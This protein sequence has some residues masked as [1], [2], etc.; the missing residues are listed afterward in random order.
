MNLATTSFIRAAI[1][2]LLV[3][4]TYAADPV[5]LPVTERYESL[6][7]EAAT[8]WTDNLWGQ[9]K[10]RL[11]IE[12]ASSLALAIDVEGEMA[13]RRRLT[14]QAGK[15]YD[16]RV[17]VSVRGQVEEAHLFLRD[18]NRP[19]TLHGRSDWVPEATWREV[20]VQIK[21]PRNSTTAVLHL[22]GRGVGTLL[23]R[24]LSI[25][26]RPDW[27]LPPA[28]PLTGELL[29]D[30]GFVLGGAGWTVFRPEF[31]EY[32]N[33]RLYLAGDQAPRFSRADPDGPWSCVL[34]AGLHETLFH[35]RPLLLNYGA[36]YRVTVRGMASADVVD[37][38]LNILK[39]DRTTP[40]YLNQFTVIFSDGVFTADFSV[41]PPPS[42]ALTA[43]RERII[44]LH[45]RGHAPARVDSVSCVE[46]HQ[47][48]VAEVPM[49]GVDLVGAI[50]AFASLLL[51]NQPGAL[52]IRTPPSLIGSPL[53]IVIADHRGEPIQTTEIP[54]ADSERAVPLG[55]L[56]IGW[57]T[58]TVHHDAN[59]L[60]QPYAF[61]VVPPI[62]PGRSGR[63]L[64]A[65][66]HS[67]DPRRVA[68]SALIGFRCAREFQ[69]DWPNMEPERGAWNEAHLSDLNRNV[70]AGIA[71]LVV[72][73]SS[74]RW[75]SSAPPA[76]LKSD[77]RYDWG[78]YPPKEMADWESYVD[79]M[80]TAGRGR[81]EAYEIW[82][83]P[84]GYHLNVPEGHTLEEA[85]VALVKAAYPVIK[86]NDP[87]ALVVVGATAGAPGDFFRRCVDQGL[88]D[89]CDVVSF[90]AYG[91]GRQASAGAPA[92]AKP[93]QMLRQLMSKVGKVKPIWDTEAGETIRPGRNGL[94]GSEV[95]LMGTISRQAAG[96]DRW[97]YYRHKPASH[98]GADDFSTVSVDERPSIL[99]P[100]LSVFDRLLGDAV[101]EQ[102]L[103][104]EA[105]GAR[106]YVFKQ[107]D[108]RRVI[109]AWRSGDGP[110][111]CD[112]SAV[113]GDGVVL[114]MFGQRTG[115]VSAGG[116]N[117]D[118][119]VRY[120]VTA[121]DV[122][123]WSDP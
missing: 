23:L 119:S 96:I 88:L 92:F 123:V 15:V 94:T 115:V 91:E 122:P 31:Y 6:D 9:P 37:L 83:E 69:F 101:F 20:R 45:H 1:V 60:G 21:P 4:A 70:E 67:F 46:L 111:R 24:G 93:V 18:D 48:I 120:I 40:I 58:A 59:V 19:F 34:P 112:I 33:E 49:V 32:R 55:R 105:T 66:H 38:R 27:D 79:R 65:H 16:I 50:D 84:N 62:Q 108:G 2:G 71:S 78:K 85:Y 3:M 41:A 95:A 28:R 81:V 118:T 13:Y 82:N 100:L 98:P 113:F 104:D 47:P 30:A 17:E 51:W 64:G 14:V 5:V 12:A 80:S 53:K 57:Y 76:K 97:Y 86:R 29:D 26:E 22:G 89:S 116:L 36:T 117:L 43:G 35:V 90:H 52:R 73:G 110:Q 56:A 42:G 75:A 77:N 8:S 11:G 25:T 72:L 107:A 109:A 7:S 10:G 102:S 74:P 39:P 99:L 106:V 54:F 61:A 121:T 63:F 68:Q 103:A 87:A 44:S 114:N